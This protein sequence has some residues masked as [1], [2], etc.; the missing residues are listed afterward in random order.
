VVI[1]SSTRQLIGGLFEY[2]DLGAVALKGFVENVPAW[3]VLTVSATES[4]FEALR[5]TTTPLVGRDEEI[6]LLLRRWELAKQGEGRVVLISG[7][8]GIGKSRIAQTVLERISTEPHT[9]LR[10][11]CSPH[12]QDSAL[13]PSVIQLE[14]ACGFRREDTPDQRLAKLEAVLA[15]GTNDLSEAVPLL[16][17]LLSIPVGDRYARL[18]LTPQKRREKTLGAQLAQV[19]GLAARQP[20]LM[21]WE[22]VHWSDP[23]TRESLDLLIDRVPSLRVLVVITFRPEFAPPW[24]GRPHVMLLTLTRL[25]LRQRVEIIEHVTRGKPLPKDIADQI[26]DR[27]DGVPLFIE[28]LTKNVIESGIV[29]EAGDHYA[30]AGPVAPLAIPSTLHASLLARLDRLAPTREIA[31]IGAALGRSFSHELI[32][33][34][35]AMPRQQL[36]SAL[37]QLANAELIFRRGT[38]PDAEYSFKHALVRDAA[39]DSML[40]SRRAQLHSKIADV[41]EGEFSDTVVNQPELLAHHFT[42]AGLNDRAVPHWIRAGQLAL[43]RVALAEAVAHLTTAL[44]MNNRLPKTVKRDREELQIRLLLASA[45]FALLGWAAIE[46]PRTLEPARNLARRLGEGE[47]LA[48]ILYYVWMHHGMRCEYQ[49]ADAATTEMYSLAKSTGGS[50]A[51]I[52]A[53]MMDACTCCWKGDFVGSRR[54]SAEVTAAYEPIIHGDLVQAIN[55]DPKCLTQVWASLA[56]WSL[57]YPDQAL[58]I[59]LDQLALARQIGHIWNLVWGLTGGG[60][61]LLLRGDTKLML[62]WCAEARAIGREHAMAVVE[63]ML[64]PGIG[65]AAMIVGGEHKEGHAGL[66]CGLGAWQ[67]SGGVHQV[68]QWKV[69]L[70]QACLGMGQA[71]QAELLVRDAMELINRTGHRMY[72]V[73]AHRVLGEVL[74]NGTRRDEGAASRAFLKA[75]EVAKSQQAK[76]WELRAATSLAHLW[77]D[78]GKR[79]QAHDLLAPVYGWFTEGFDTLDLKEAKSLLDELA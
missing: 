79:T 51:L 28:E 61:T 16:A 73:E 65:G 29:T 15:Q 27:T 5:A 1:A 21:V 25:P 53:Q 24:S 22:D 69:I 38:P 18:D 75:L 40:K 56:S 71:D 72:E 14:R 9:R 77:R 17:D 36:D 48:S 30:A 33:A 34:V 11:F 3:Q 44:T 67:T 6:D 49:M 4:R 2:H 39:Y 66:S 31:Q 76:S 45:Y 20:V 23:T 68:P 42:Q 35:A 57:G 7:E 10:Y 46:V 12:H 63:H 74:L 78:Q 54:V 47:K 55:H 19:E 60:L 52:T 13:Y 43:E 70:A 32:S 26:A 41:L 64:F 37:A 62:E 50:S 59:S 58:R 8:P